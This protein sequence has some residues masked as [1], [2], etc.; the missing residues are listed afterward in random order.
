MNLNDQEIEAKF[1]ICSLADIEQRLRNLGAHLIQQRTHEANL[2][3]DTSN[4]NFKRE[5]R[6]LRL[7][8]D[9]AIRLT[10]KDGSRKRD[11]VILRREIEFAVSDFDSARKFIEA[12]GYQVVFIYEK[13]RSTYELDGVHIMLDEMPYGN[14]V[15][16]EGELASLKPIAE[17]L[18]LNWDAAIPTGYFALFEKVR[19]ARGL[20]FRDLSFENFKGIEIEA[21]DLKVVSAD[22]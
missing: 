3:F 9:D 21:K 1:Y 8:R 16:I 2:R 17:K 13:Y 18:G 5:G 19:E 15:E 22:K 6:V 11:G 4:G 14:F 20:E 7:R 12:L 10:Y